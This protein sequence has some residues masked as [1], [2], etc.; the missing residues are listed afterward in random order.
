MNLA[1]YMWQFEDR[2]QLTQEQ[3]NKFSQ[4]GL[5][6]TPA[7][8]RLCLQR[9]LN[10]PEAIKNAINQNPTIYHDPFLLYQMD[11]AVDR[12]ERAIA[13]QELITIYGDYDAD[14]ITSTLIL[15]ESLEAIGANVNYYLPNRLVDGYGPN[16]ERYEQL[17]QEG[18]QLILTCDNGVSGHEA[19]AYA[20]D[21]GVDVIVTDH[22]Q[23]QE[24]LPVAY[25]IIHP[26][27]PQG[28][29]PFSE[30]SGAGVALKLVSA[31]IDEIPAE[32][33]EL[34]AIGTVAD[35]VSL[36]DENRTIVI[37]GLNRLRE[38]QREGL[39]KLFEQQ[40]VD[41]SNLQ[42]DD[43]GFLIGPRLNAVGRLGDP[44][45]GLELLRSFDPIEASQYVDFINQKND[46]RKKIVNNIAVEVESRI[47]QY[48]KIPDIIIESDANW[49]AGVLGIVASRIVER[50][51]RPAIIFQKIEADKVYKGSG[52][53]IEAIDLFDTLSQVSN[54][55]KYFGGH[56]QAAG[57]TVDFEQWEN[58]T[59]TLLAVVE[60]KSATISYTPSLTINLSLGLSDVSNQFI[61]EV[62]LLGPFGIDNPKPI[63]AF[64]N[65]TIDQ[66]RWIGTEQQHLKLLLAE[67]QASKDPSVLNAIGFNCKADYQYLQLSNQISIVGKLAINEWQQTRTPQLMI[68]DIGMNGSQWVD[69][70]GSQIPTD[71][72][73]YQHTLYVFEH[74]PIFDVYREKI[75]KTSYAIRYSD[76]KQ[77]ST[78]INNN[79]IKYLAIVEPPKKIELLEE[80]LLI[81][82][83]ETVYL[84]SYTKESKYLLGLPTR[85][86]TAIVYRWIQKNKAIDAKN[87]VRVLNNETQIPLTK[88]KLILKLF[89]QASF[90][91]MNGG[92]LLFNENIKQKVDLA[93]LPAMHEF[94]ESMKVEE[95]LNFQSLNQVKKTL[96]KEE[97]R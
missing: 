13:D 78:L 64:E 57:L 84:G 60:S 79:E 49:P 30:L 3:L 92:R 83:W 42:V 26:Q 25:A 88:I 45:P 16:L 73:N 65:V 47:S 23:F 90:V 33:L 41:I 61:E 86:E 69:K 76:L 43:I 18:T 97:Q 53:S 4:A 93:N 9:G 22:H 52:R 24:K 77:I 80:L 44:T 87:V 55:I 21:A 66:L 71:F 63:F 91:T 17:I 81:Q 62:D 70:R 39:R 95:L 54:Q 75:S 10:S 74:Q 32:A 19:L 72:F 2:P 34:A 31:L 15:F 36:T 82:F 38:T 29:Y 37:N 12:I 35:L 67:N 94:R 58:F 59:T 68:K 89:F 7:F 40:K 28:D 27:H 51:H 5:N 14:G 48:D 96:E 8:L 11:V 6:L 1:K 46:E 56:S 50:Y 85:D 20:M